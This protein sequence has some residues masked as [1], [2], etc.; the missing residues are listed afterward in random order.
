MYYRC[1]LKAAQFTMGLAPE[2]HYSEATGDDGRVRNQTQADPKN[3]V[4]E[5]FTSNDHFVLRDPANETWAFPVGSNQSKAAAYKLHDRYKFNGLDISIENRAGSKRYWTEAGTGEKGS[6]KMLYDYGYIRKTEGMDGDHVDV[7]IGPNE[8]A[9]NVYVI[10]TNM[11]P[12]FKK[13]DEQKCMLG[14][15][16]AAAAKEAY[17]K[18]YTDKR[19][20]RDMKEMPFEEFKTKVLDK[21]NHGAKLATYPDQTPGDY[22]GFPPTQLTGPRKVLGLGPSQSQAI[23]RSFRSIDQ[24]QATINMEGGANYPSGPSA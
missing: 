14:F 22:L 8:A 19:F 18:H 13:P 5:A 17:L 15:D 23:E 11:A 16:S 4:N 1:G 2:E 3:Q 9:K 24:N 20:F 21:E 10:M 6:T 12:D 7:F